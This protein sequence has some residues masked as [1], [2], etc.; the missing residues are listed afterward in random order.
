MYMELERLN[1]HKCLRDILSY[2]LIF[3]NIILGVVLV[4]SKTQMHLKTYEQHPLLAGRRNYLC[5]LCSYRLGDCSLDLLHGWNLFQCHN[6]LFHESGGGLGIQ[7]GLSSLLCKGQFYMLGW[8][9]MYVGNSTAII[10]IIYV[11]LLCACVV[12]L[13]TSVCSRTFA[14]EQ[15]LPTL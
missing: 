5:A 1:P 12:S 4:F 8:K 14:N 10:V 11:V 15:L 6:V 3:F 7:K 13:V 9:E 2:I